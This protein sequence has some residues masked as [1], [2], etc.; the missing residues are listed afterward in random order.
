MSDTV[1]TKETCMWVGGFV[2]V[3][4]IIAGIIWGLMV[5]TRGIR[6]DAKCDSLALEHRIMGN[7]VT[8]EF[9]EVDAWGK[10]LRAYYSEDKYA[11]VYTVKS[12]GAD[13]RFNTPDDISGS[14]KN[15][16]ISRM[17]GKFTMTKSMEVGGGMKDA[18]VEKFK[19]TDEDS[20]A[21][22]TGR[23][24]GSVWGDLKKGFAESK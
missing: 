20:L 18:V 16:N 7:A 22:K 24:L 3:C 8:G 4:L 23:K 1:T 14:H 2:G 9:G 15:R 10:K 21:K 5:L 11:K 12:A 19:P 6:T 13:G 17:I